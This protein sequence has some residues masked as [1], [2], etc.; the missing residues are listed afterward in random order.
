MNKKRELKNFKT[1]NK[2]AYRPLSAFEVNA[3]YLP[4][5]NS[6]YIPV[7]ILQEPFYSEE[8]LF[9]ENL[10]SLGNIIAH[11]IAHSIFVND[12]LLDENNYKHFYF[13]YEYYQKYREWQ[14]KIV[15]LYSNYKNSYEIKEDGVRTFY[16]N[17]ADILGMQACLNVLKMKNSLSENYSNFFEFYAR[18]KVGVT[19]DLY[20]RTIY[21]TE[22]HSL[23]EARVNCVLKNFNEFYEVYF[24]GQKDKMYISPK[25]RARF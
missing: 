7:G 18:S 14:K 4:F 19:S 2:D 15:K 8:F 10:G 12:S 13:N 1:F 21:L 25:H 22:T 17:S 9:E 5:T 6:V 16:E 3:Y 23:P 24:V 11:E 20:N